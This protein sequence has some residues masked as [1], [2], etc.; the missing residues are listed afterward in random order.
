MST[1]THSQV[2]TD[3]EWVVDPANSI[4]EFAVKTFWGAM[5][6]R[7]HF[8]TFDGHYHVGPSGSSIELTIDAGSLTTD[9]EKRDAHLRSEDFFHVERHPSVRFH[10]TRVDETGDGRIHVQGELQAAGRSV[11]L[12]FDAAVRQ[13]AGGLEVDAATTVDQGEFG[14]TRGMLAMIRPPARLHVRTHLVRSE[15]LESAPAER[16]AA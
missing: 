3:T 7:G 13:V 15:Q 8:E 11:P 1:I 10:S 4:V 6:V 5:T 16:P 14:M 9:H 12:E 2:A